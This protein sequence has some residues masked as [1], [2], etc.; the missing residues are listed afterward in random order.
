MRYV[1]AVVV[2]IACL[3]G[4]MTSTA[5]GA[6]PKPKCKATQTLTKKR[7]TKKVWVTYK[8]KSGRKHRKR[9]TVKQWQYKCVAKKR[10]VQPKPPVVADPSPLPSPSPDPGAAPVPAPANPG[11][12]TQPQPQPT[13]PQPTDQ[14]ADTAEPQP[15]P[16]GPAMLGVVE[17]EW[18][19]T[20][21]RTT[22]P[23]GPVNV[24][25]INFGEDPH[26]LAFR[27]AGQPQPW[28]SF[29]T[30]SFE[31]T[32][33]QTINLERGTWSLICSLSGHEQLGMRATV[34]VA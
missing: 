1:I 16:S 20:L 26:N 12:P 8:D 28:A 2:A 19:I 29:P 32:H 10:P 3:T 11:T 5:A 22:L 14:P 24:D 33:S 27:R 21:S 17:R 34:T 7:V 15:T 31:Q 6:T 13:N 4:S 30:I 18:S 25:V 23:A 9:K